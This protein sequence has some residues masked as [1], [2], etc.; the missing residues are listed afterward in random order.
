MT[1]AYVIAF[2][3]LS[4]LFATDIYTPSMPEIGRF[5]GESDDQVQRTISYFLLGSVL[6]CIAAG[7]FADQV[8]KKKFLMWGMVL[9]VFGSLL[10]L[11]ASTLEWLI[12]GRFI[13]GLGSGV[14]PVIGYAMIQELYSREKQ[15]KIYAIM[16]ILVSGVPAVAPL[17]GGIISTYFGW[18]IIF[19][20][21]AATFVVST[22]LAGIYLPSSLNHKIPHSGMEILRSYKEILSSRAFLALALLSPMFNSVEWFYLTYLPFYAQDNIGISPEFYGVVVGILIA[23]F[24]VGSSL[25][26]YM[27]GKFGL[28]R[29]IQ[30]G[31]YCGL[32]AGLMLWIATIWCPLSLLGISLSLSVFFIGFGILFPSSVSASLSVFEKARTRASSVRSLFI[33]GFAFIGSFVAEL[34][35]DKNLSS[36]AGYVS[37]CAV[38]AFLIYAMR[39]R[40]SGAL[41]H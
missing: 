39:K 8:G 31:L 1:N 23:W 4:Y 38:A 20:L 6:T 13:Q 27:M 22:V 33:T 26:A 15:A 21:I 17:M 14:G 12:L 19:V 11:M 35:D 2:G 29:T 36:L 32:I 34:V 24:A 3:I 41:K 9:A 5:F 40:E 16:A 18:H 10:T 37:I 28:H 7:V 30:A 25:G